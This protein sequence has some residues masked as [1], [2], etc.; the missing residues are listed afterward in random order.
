[1]LNKKLIPTIWI[2]SNKIWRLINSIIKF[3]YNFSYFK[4]QLMIK[5]LGKKHINLQL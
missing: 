2:L 4:I 1:M 3:F 5:L